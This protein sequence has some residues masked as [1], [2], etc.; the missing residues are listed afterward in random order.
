MGSATINLASAGLE[1]NEGTIFEHSRTDIAGVDFFDDDESSTITEQQI[2]SALGVHSRPQSE[3]LFLP[4]VSEP[5]AVRHFTRLSKKN[6]AIDTQIYPLGS[7][8]MKYNPKVHEWVAR[9]PGITALHPYMAQEDL[10][11][12]LRIIW[13]MQTWLSEIGG[14]NQTSLAPSAGAQGEWAGL[15]MITAALK[16]RGEKRHTILVP[17][18]AHGTNPATAA[19][20]GYEVA[21]LDIGADGRVIFSQVEQ[22]MG[23]DCAGI[24]ITNPNTLGIFETELAQISRLVHERGGYVYG[25]GANLNAL[26]GITRPGDLGVDVMHF[27]LHKTFT[28][29]HGGGGPGCGAIGASQALSAYL[30][31]PLVALNRGVFEVMSD[32]PQSIGAIRTF[33]GNFGLLVRALSYIMS[34]GADGL[35]NASELAVLNAN[36]IKAKLKPY[37]HLPYNTDCLHEVVFSHKKQAEHGVTALDIAKR[38]IDYGVHPPTMYFPLVVSGALMIEPTETESRRDLDYLINA[39]IAVA[40]EAKENPDLV[41]NAPHLTALKRLDEAKAARNPVLRVQDEAVQD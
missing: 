18:S 12:A 8:T 21:P 26:M 30:P 32:L 11:P 7:C 28:T 24:M 41:K 19:F 3:T 16:Q 6:F 34:L 39:F 10:Q 31:K 23:D 15:A 33:Y 1:L 29:P 14:F 25:D 5:E 36:Y 13:Q 9:L 20:F 22:L 38:L 17:N 4:E 2:I 35:K 27:N 37:Y 40:N